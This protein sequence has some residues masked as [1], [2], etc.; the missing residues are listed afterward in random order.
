MAVQ[1]SDGNS[2]TYLA[3]AAYLYSLGLINKGQY[4]RFLSA[5]QAGRIQFELIDNHCRCWL[6]GV[7]KYNGDLPDAWIAALGSV[8]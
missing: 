8:V 1:W 7:L 3:M 6:D 2:H 5:V 4:N